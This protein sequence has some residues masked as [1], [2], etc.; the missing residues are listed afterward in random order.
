MKK[1]EIKDDDIEEYKKKVNPVDN[2]IVSSRNVIRFI[3]DL[4]P[5]QKIR[6]E[7]IKNEL[8]LVVRP[9]KIR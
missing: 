9:K 1:L 6:E 5:N 7:G 4:H 3:Q 2:K 8:K